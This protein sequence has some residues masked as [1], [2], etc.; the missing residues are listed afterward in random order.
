M[1]TEL[2]ERPTIIEDIQIAQVIT[3]EFIARFEK[4][5][6]LY[7]TRYL[8]LCLKLTNEG[9]WINHGTERE[10][11][12][13]LQASGAEKVG[14][15]LGITWDR[16]AV[17]KHERQDD[18]GPY[19]EYEVEG[20]VHSRILARYGWFTGNCSSRDQFFNARG[21]YDEGDIRK[22]AF[23]NWLVNAITRL[24]G[25]RN[26]SPAMLVLAGLKPEQVKK[27]DYSGRHLPE[28]ESYPISEGQQKRLWAIA[29][30]KGVSQELIRGHL[31]KNYGIIVTG[32]IKRRDY[33]A[34][35]AW[36][37]RGGKEA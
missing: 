10:P 21:H 19:Y 25:I 16:P 4:A 28:Q 18:K 2:A 23:S 34:V 37:E 1:S 36:V 7:Q 26:P 14:N 15:P 24:A 13:G 8:P 30:E 11:K 22:S 33:D 6:A 12:Y 17:H 31:E 35:V 5:A 32:E 3:E 9:D 20:V 29:R 27:V